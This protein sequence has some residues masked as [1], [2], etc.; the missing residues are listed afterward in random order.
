MNEAVDTA[1]EGLTHEKARRE[2]L[3]RRIEATDTRTQSVTKELQQSKKALEQLEISSFDEKQTLLKQIHSIEADL[4]Q[5]K[6]LRIIADKRTALL[7]TQAQQVAEAHS[8]LAS[9]T[10]S[11]H[12]LLERQIEKQQQDI[13]DLEDA[14]EKT[15]AE[16]Q[17]N[18][19]TLCRTQ[20][21]LDETLTALQQ[22]KLEA[23]VQLETI[24]HEMQEEAQEALLELTQALGLQFEEMKKVITDECDLL[25]SS[26]TSQHETEKQGLLHDLRQ[27]KDRLSVLEDAYNTDMS[28]L[29][30]I[31]EDLQQ[32]LEDANQ[33][34]FRFR[35][36]HH[37]SKITVEA[38]L[39][40]LKD[41]RHCL[42][43]EL[44]QRSLELQDK[45]SSVVHLSFELALL[46]TQLQQE[47]E[48]QQEEQKAGNHALPSQL[49]NFVGSVFEKT[50]LVRK[51]IATF[52]IVPELVES[53]DSMVEIQSLTDL[54]SIDEKMSCIYSQL[55][56]LVP[57]LL[58]VSSELSRSR[59][60]AAD[61]RLADQSTAAQIKQFKQE[62]SVLRQK[63]M[64]L[65][66]ETEHQ[67][68]ERRLGVSSLSSLTLGESNSFN[69]LD[70]KKR[71][72]KHTQ[73]SVATIVS[74]IEDGRV[75]LKRHLEREIEFHRQAKRQIVA[76]EGMIDTLRSEVSVLSAASHFTTGSSSHLPEII[77]KS[78][79][80]LQTRETLS[81][82][83]SDIFRSFVC[84][85]LSER[86]AL[87]Q[88][89]QQQLMEKQMIS[90]R[91][92]MACD[93]LGRLPIHEASSFS[94]ISQPTRL[95][96]GFEGILHQLE[97]TVEEGDKEN[98]PP[99]DFVS[100]ACCNPTADKGIF[101]MLSD[102]VDPI[103]IQN[104]PQP[105]TVSVALSDYPSPSTSPTLKRKRVVE[106]E[107]P[108]V[109][110][111]GKSNKDREQQ[112]LSAS[113]HIGPAETEIPFPQ[114]VGALHKNQSCPA[115]L[116][117]N[118]GNSPLSSPI[119]KRHRVANLKDREKSPSREAR[120][121]DRD[122]ALVLLNI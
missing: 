2:L 62:A 47:N 60:T 99:I 3:E 92:T 19:N 13:H 61:L 34:L 36:E 121:K 70:G 59:K 100:F 48:R 95:L 49:E 91:L 51:A 24:I 96:A 67:Q 22:S 21:S 108:L 109:D 52:K 10:D 94:S 122:R 113:A 57:F 103:N 83:L 66:V 29:Q 78:L 5:E 82:G 28:S 105:L 32:Q 16:A 63:L 112:A 88:N 115:E 118:T 86:E 65:Q 18:Q 40:T 71:D 119:S 53:I 90:S 41:E 55:A 120:Y 30:T 104:S 87:Q 45:A 74:S 101:S 106:G 79:C 25:I 23:K 7:E 20:G 64:E 31:N 107:R 14:L 6:Q 81:S 89:L 26:L 15:R 73:S 56:G 69:P 43:E 46:R 27:L 85:I 9:T 42:S 72:P 98:V 8:L 76:M 68:L 44:N 35:K 80:D 117:E 17:L 37:L 116:K 75:L 102:T 84:Q 1:E 12:S 97:E 4:H 54:H 11:D 114:T 50:I 93:L 111:F 38:Q 110:S 58:T 39:E 77:E 33:T